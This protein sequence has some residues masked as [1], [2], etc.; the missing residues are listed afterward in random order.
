MSKVPILEII[1]ESGDPGLSI[2]FKE[3][4]SCG[5]ITLTVCQLITEKQ[6]VR[7]K[8]NEWFDSYLTF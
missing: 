3:N 5:A 2:H 8:Y 6:P 4:K 7:L 1:G